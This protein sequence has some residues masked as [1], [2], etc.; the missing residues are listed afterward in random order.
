MKWWLFISVY[1][2]K[3]AKYTPVDLKYEPIA[4]ECWVQNERMCEAWMYAPQ[5]PKPTL[6]NLGAGICGNRRVWWNNMLIDNVILMTDFTLFAFR[7]CFLQ[8][9]PR[10][11][12]QSL[13]TFTFHANF[14]FY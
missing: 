9:T 11:T 8:N 6:R 13:Y 5:M 3:I 2:D 7:E 1:G 12:K 10:N 14:M 4:D